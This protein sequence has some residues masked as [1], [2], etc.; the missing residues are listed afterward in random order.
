MD[1]G[2]GGNLARV[3]EAVARGK[4]RAGSVLGRADPGPLPLLLWCWA[5][6]LYPQLLRVATVAACVTLATT[7]G[8]LALVSSGALAPHLVVRACAAGELLLCSGARPAVV[9]AVLLLWGRV[10]CAAV[11]WL[12]WTA[13]GRLQLPPQLLCALCAAGAVLVEWVR[14]CL[15]V[16]VAAVA[17]RPAPTL[18]KRPTSSSL[19]CRR[20]AMGPKMRRTSLPAISVQRNQMPLAVQVS[21][22]L[23]L[24]I[25][26]TFFNPKKII[27]RNRDTPCQPSRYR[28]GNANN[29]GFDANT[30]ETAGAGR[31]ELPWKLDSAGHF[32]AS[33]S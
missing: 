4:A 26:K 7:G 5:A 23:R 28:P 14:S 29:G 19:P 13:V 3:W 17:E 2:E 33:R 10:V 24:G 12:L 21:L 30:G 16:R 15:S 18:L 25:K 11:L 1:S 32:P 8:L 9:C 20:A 22:S 27:R 31:P 6:W